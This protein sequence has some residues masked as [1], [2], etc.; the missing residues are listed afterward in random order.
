ME[1]F[2]EAENAEDDD[3]GAHENAG[4]DG[5]FLHAYCSIAY[6]FPVHFPTYFMKTFRLLV[7]VALLLAACSSTAPEA[8]NMP[9]SDTPSLG[10]PAIDENGNPSSVD[11]MVVTEDAGGNGDAADG[12][13]TGMRTVHM[14]VTDWA[15]TPS[16]ITLKK[17]EKITL[18]LTGVDGDHGISAP[19]LGIE[20]KFEA[21]ETVMVTVPTDKT[22]TFNFRCNVPCGHGHRDMTGTIIIEE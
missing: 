21:G 9:E 10:M 4:C 2:I 20:K 14:D 17:G 16:T 7:P 13:A 15:F 22:G 5:I 1:K 18:E 11:E 3:H 19:D 6:A 8:G 12:G